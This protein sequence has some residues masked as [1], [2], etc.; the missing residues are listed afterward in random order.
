VLFR[1][2]FLQSPITLHKYLYANNNPS[3]L[4]DPSGLFSLAGVMVG[5]STSIQSYVQFS[6]A[7]AIVAS[8]TFASV[9]YIISP[10]IEARALGLEL[11]ADDVPGGFEIYQAGNDLI[12][13]GSQVIK[14]TSDVTNVVFAGIGLTKA[15]V[16]PPQLLLKTISTH[17]S[18]SVAFAQI[19]RLNGKADVIFRNAPKLRGRFTDIGEPIRD[20]SENLLE[21]VK[22]ARKAIPTIVSELK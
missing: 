12:Y 20:Y 21:L 14:L 16:R 22:L 13:A 18:N 2:G 11:I 19:N 3:T 4:T 1:S 5:L 6:G 17:Y 10:G 15:I 9:R 7:K 8:A